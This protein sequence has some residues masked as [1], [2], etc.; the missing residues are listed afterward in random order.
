MANTHTIKITGQLRLVTTTLAIGLFAS[1]VQASVSQGRLQ[2]TATVVEACSLNL[3][4]P[5]VQPLGRFKDTTRMSSCENLR[6]NNT[7]TA[8]TNSAKSVATEPLQRG[9]YNLDVDES[10]GQVTLFF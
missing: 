4:L 9:Q 3:A 8:A 5:Q 1:Q 2:I 10:S 6:T 7:A